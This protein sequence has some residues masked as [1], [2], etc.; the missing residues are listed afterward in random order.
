MKQVR[1]GWLHMQSALSTILAV[2]HYLIAHTSPLQL[3]KKSILDIKL[4]CV[5]AFSHVEEILLSPD[6]PAPLRGHRQSDDSS[7]LIG[8]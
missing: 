8:P 7:T 1:G 6:K 5:L 3:L 2:R 4:H